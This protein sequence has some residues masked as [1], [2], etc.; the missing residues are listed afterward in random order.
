M[1]QAAALGAR[2]MFLEVAAANAAARAL[3]AA[4]GFTEVGL[5]RRYYGNGDDAL[6]LRCTMPKLM[7]S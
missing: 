7:L 1:A 4:H 3:Y 5:R 2:T 6:M